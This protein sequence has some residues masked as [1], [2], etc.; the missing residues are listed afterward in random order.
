MSRFSGSARAGTGVQKSAQGR[1]I[2]QRDT[3]STACTFARCAVEAD[4]VEVLTLLQK[5]CT[6]ITDYTKICSIFA[7]GCKEVC[8]VALCHALR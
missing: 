4:I 6:K 3:M 7:L 5:L 1:I 8:F 2:P